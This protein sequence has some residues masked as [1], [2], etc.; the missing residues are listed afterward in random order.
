MRSWVYLIG[1][2]AHYQD[3]RVKEASAVYVVALP[4]EQEL[5]QVNME[6]YASEYLPQNIAISAGKAYAVGTDWE[7]KEPE[8]FKIKGMREDL[9]LYIFQEG[10][11]FEDGLVA[12]FRILCEEL[13][14]E[15]K[16]ISLEPIVD[17]GSPSYELMVECLRKALSA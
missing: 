7:I 12:V 6:C 14:R 13:Y 10:L 3:G 4:S 16:P 1:I 9:E 8:R 15:G 5:A 11:N 17:V 2:R